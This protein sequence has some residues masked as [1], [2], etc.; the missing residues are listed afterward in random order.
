MN[1]T[2]DH[3]VNLDINKM[4]KNLERE[5]EDVDEKNMVLSQKIFEKMKFYCDYEGLNFFT[6]SK[7]ECIYNLI[8]IL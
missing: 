7:Y 8:D 4:E 6:S 3:I 5:M 1:D 2:Y